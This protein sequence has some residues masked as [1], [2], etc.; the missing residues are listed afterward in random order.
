[1]TH[2]IYLALYKGRRSGSGRQV[3]LA[4]ATDWLTRK[5]TRGQYSHA[6]IA[7]RFPENNADGAAQ[8]DC[9]SA[10]VRDG[11]VRLK[12]MP[13]PAAKWDLIPLPA[14]F[15]R[16][17]LQQLWERT[18]GQPYDLCGALGI[19]FGL[20]ENSRRWFCSE[21]CAEVIGLPE[22]WRFSPNDL[23]AIVRALTNTTPK[24]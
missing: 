4:R 14:K 17:R 7:V 13:L 20:P 19:A 1:M 5:I 10:S 12:T 21:W 2:Q 15:V 16:E 9:Y 11:G 24:L 23:A 6:E 8:Y 18:G 22:S 3:W